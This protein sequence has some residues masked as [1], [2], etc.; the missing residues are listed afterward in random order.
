MVLAIRAWSEQCVLHQ[1]MFLIVSVVIHHFLKLAFVLHGLSILHLLHHRIN[2]ESTYK[3][4]FCRQACHRLL[5]LSARLALHMYLFGH[6][7]KLCSVSKHLLCNHVCLTKKSERKADST[8][9]SSQAVPHPST[10]RALR[11]LTSEVKRDPVHSTR[12]GRQRQ[13]FCRK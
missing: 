2:F 11:C 1:H 3:H 12:Y 6:N 10:D 5:L 8:L 4:S 9:R 7:Q 13:T